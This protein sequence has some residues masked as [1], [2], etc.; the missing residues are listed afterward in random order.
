MTWFSGILLDE[1]MT[2]KNHE[3]C[4]E[5]KISKKLGIL[6]KARWL[7]QKKCIKQLYFSFVH[8]YLNCGNIAWASTNKTKQEADSF[9]ISAPKNLKRLSEI[10]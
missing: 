4:V 9:K 5:N 2:C 3:S 6:Y 1:N 10:T 7:L 8:S